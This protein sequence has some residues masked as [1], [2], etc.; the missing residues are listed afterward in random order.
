MAYISNYT[1]CSPLSLLSSPGLLPELLTVKNASSVL[2][3]N[4]V[5][6]AI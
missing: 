6:D 4:L 5:L 2:D 1:Y 3:T